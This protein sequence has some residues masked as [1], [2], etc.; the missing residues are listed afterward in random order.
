[1]QF[2]FR[3]LY[4]REMAVLQVIKEV[5]KVGLAFDSKRARREAAKLKSR[6]EKAWM[7]VT[8]Y[9]SDDFTDHYVKVLAMLRQLGVPERRLLWQNKPSSRAEVLDRLVAEGTTKRAAEF[10]AALRLYRNC[11]KTINTYLLK[12]ANIADRNDGVI[13]TQLNPADTKTGR[14]ASRDP[15]LQNLPNVHKEYSHIEENPVRF[16]FV[17]RR[18]FANYYFDYVQMELVVFGLYAQDEHIVE[19][20]NAGEDLHHYMARCVYEV[21]EPTEQQR[22]ATK[23]ISFGIIYGEGIRTLQMNLRC[24]QAKARELLDI[25]YSKFP[26][27]RQYGDRLKRLLYKHGYI[28]GLFGKRYTLTRGQAYKAINKIIQGECAQIFKVALLKLDSLLKP[29]T[30]R[31]LLPIHD[32]FQ[33]ERRWPAPHEQTWARTVVGCMTDIPQLLDRGLRLRV[34]V[35]KTLTNWAEKHP[36]E[37]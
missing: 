4:A 7:I 30:E 5:E 21:D 34:D 32:E 14:M 1:M 33:I 28:E 36:L 12:F 19:A 37:I 11:A 3:K 13:H 24:T 9:T 23:N 2:D 15:N 27:I 8:K 20:Y 31:I 16:C 29:T 18:S 6:M 25:Y 26:S 10:I 35:D 22:Q 17:P